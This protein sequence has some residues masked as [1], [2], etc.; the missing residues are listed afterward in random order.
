MIVLRAVTEPWL[1]RFVGHHFSLLICFYLSFVFPDFILV[2]EP[3]ARRIRLLKNDS[4]FI[5]F[6]VWDLDL[7]LALACY[8][9]HHGLVHQEQGKEGSSQ[10][11][12]VY[13]SPSK[14]LHHSDAA[15]TAARTTTRTAAA[16]TTAAA[17]TTKANSHAGC[18]IDSITST[19]AIS[20]LSTSPTTASTTAIATISIAP[21]SKSPLLQ[22][23]RRPISALDP[24]SRLSPTTARMAPTGELP[25]RH[26]EPALLPQRTVPARTTA[27]APSPVPAQLA[28]QVQQVDGQPRQGCR[29]GLG[30]A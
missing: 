3:R 4:T 21:T 19:S 12:T 2:E 16:T 15:A 7:V 29:A 18:S 22:P 14:R 25:A 17:Y 27:A 23:V 8:I 28:R 5:V 13:L 11:R 10:L 9:H 24:T 26:R 1:S 6:G 20:I 30:G